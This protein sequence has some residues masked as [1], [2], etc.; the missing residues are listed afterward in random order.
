MVN[1]LEWVSHA[2]VKIGGSELP[3]ETMDSLIDIV[4]DTTL[5]LPTLFEMRFNDSGFTLTDGDTFE[6]GKAVDIQLSSGTDEIETM[7]AGEI[8]A[9]EV[10]YSENLTSQLIVRGY[11]RSY[12]LNR[13]PKTRVFVQMK[14]SDI[15]KQIAGET[16]LSP[17]VTETSQVFEHIFQDNQTD[18]D[19]LQDHARRLGFEVFVNDKTLYFREPKGERGDIILSWGEALRSF[20]PRMTLTHQVD[21]VIVRGWNFVKK[22]KV[23]GQASRG[24]TST[25]IGA[26]DDGGALATKAFSSEARQVIVRRPVNEQAEADRLAQAILDEINSEFVEAEGNALGTPKLLAGTLIKVEN[27]GQRFSGDY[28]VT[29]AV[30]NY[31]QGS[32]RVNFRVEGAYARTLADLLVDVQNTVDNA[33]T[34]GGVFPAIVTNNQDPD[35]LGRVKL[36]FPWMDNELESHWARI[37]SIGAGA[38]R[39]I[40]MMP[41]VNDEVLVAFEHGNFN[42]PYVIGA[43]WNGKDALPETEAVK[44]GNVVLRTIKSRTGHVIRISDTEGESYILIEDAEGKN[45][46]Q[47][48][49]TNDKLIIETSG[50]VNVNS[51]GDTKVET[52]ANVNIK[53]AQNVSI[54]GSSNVEIKGSGGVTVQSSG[55]LKLSGSIVNIN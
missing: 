36:K 7:F 31:Q 51:K 38:E 37:A 20:R 9:V 22:E 35:K 2:V 49:T 55:E 18:L 30:H 45:K 10:D 33:A 32:Y 54:E 53:A 12:R 1:N 50:E 13:E 47:L 4:V 34:W 52:K 17:E 11:D 8:T 41:E 40:F 25:R 44:N 26:G 46:I 19:F 43:L 14:V 6:P 29:S 39:G 28:M 16:N 3:P 27:L 23:V 48:D 42:R 5:H 15:V 24:K 21:E